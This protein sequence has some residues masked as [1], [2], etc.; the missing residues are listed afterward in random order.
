M[1]EMSFHS[2]DARL[3]ST[4]HQRDRGPSERRVIMILSTL[5]STTVMEVHKNLLP[6]LK[7]ENQREII[8]SLVTSSYHSRSFP[9]AKKECLEP[10][11]CL[12]MTLVVDM[13]TIVDLDSNEKSLS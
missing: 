6:P 10:E 13:N 3:I 8:S 4:L 5:K 1:M 2:C 12:K 7:M 11:V 9:A